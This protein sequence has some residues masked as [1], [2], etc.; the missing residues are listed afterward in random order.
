MTREVTEMITA[1]HVVLALY[2]V[3]KH[4]QT[5]NETGQLCCA[6]IGCRYYSSPTALDGGL[7][8]TLFF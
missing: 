5:E 7:G 1:I 8:W 6:N 2:P 3:E 4:F